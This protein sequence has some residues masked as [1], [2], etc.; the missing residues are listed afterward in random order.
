MYAPTPYDMPYMGDVRRLVVDNNKDSLSFQ[1]TL[2]I[3]DISGDLRRRTIP[4][5]SIDGFNFSLVIYPAGNPNLVM[6][7]PGVSVY[8]KCQP[9]AKLL[10]SW[11]CC[12]DFTLTLLSKEKKDIFWRSSLAEHRFMSTINTW[13]IHCMV[14]AT[15][16]SGYVDKTD[17]SISIRVSA[18]L[19]KIRVV[20]VC[21]GKDHVGP[22]FMKDGVEYCLPYS[23]TLYCLRQRIGWG[24]KKLWLFTQAWPSDVFA[25]AVCLD[26][27]SPS[28]TIGS[29]LTPF[30]N[31]L[32]TA[33][34][35]IDSD[36]DNTQ[37]DRTMVHVKRVGYDGLI[38]MVGS[39]YMATDFDEL[40]FT[41][42][43]DLYYFIE[44]APPL[45][46]RPL[47]APLQHGQVIVTSMMGIKEVRS[48][49]QRAYLEKT[50]LATGLLKK[51]TL[52]ISEVVSAYEAMGGPGVRAFN[53]YRFKMNED[54]VKTMAYILSGRHVGY[55]C[56]GCGKTDF[57][58]PRYHCDTC[59]DYDLCSS[60]HDH[61]KDSWS[62]RYQLTPNN[63][64]VRIQ[65]KDDPHT[66]HH[67]MTTVTPLS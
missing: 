47:D 1:S 36:N 27:F 51:L 58:G 24:D 60:C 20:V 63:Q 7:N 25:P 39:M 45:C 11:E 53:L 66:I 42:G 32:S 41:H 9:V 31:G 17:D 16:L 61:K 2:S 15:D 4:I 5:T 37:P 44:C 43:N 12:C 64:F 22:G 29:I 10:I 50:R 54:P 49:F 19:K 23:M 34:I 21:G 28:A 26:T 59:D 56:D 67:T 46:V 13:G 8:L 40:R 35:W 30:T 14:S 55:C 57:M 18:V 65:N 48:I 6:P 33:R 3:P 62:F 38:R 52:T